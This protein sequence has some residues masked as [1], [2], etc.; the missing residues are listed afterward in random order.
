MI[1][2]L[3]IQCKCWE[4]SFVLQSAYL[5]RRVNFHYRVI[6]NGPLLQ[7]F[8]SQHPAFPPGKRNKG[9]LLPGTHE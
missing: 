3:K 4:F 9:Y 1:Y 2:L 8:A 6:D 5:Q 7:I